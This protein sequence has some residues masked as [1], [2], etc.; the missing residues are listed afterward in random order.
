MILTLT[1]TVSDMVWFQMRCVKSV[2]VHLWS[3]NFVHL[4]GCVSQIPW[5]GTQNRWWLLLTPPF[6]LSFAYMSVCVCTV[7]VWVSL[8]RCACVYHVDTLVCVC[9][10]TPHIIL[11][12]VLQACWARWLMPPQTWT[13]LK[14]SANWTTTTDQLAQG[15]G[16]P[17]ALVRSCLN[18]PESRL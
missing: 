12:C 10:K 8:F 16:R 7:H 3:V 2:T 14:P 11:L 18:A 5:T 4:W 1:L 6:S 9:G 17:S 13:T 15:S